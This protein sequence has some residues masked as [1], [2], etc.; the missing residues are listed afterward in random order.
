M[1][2]ES[3]TIGGDNI[4]VKE[5]KGSVDGLFARLENDI[6]RIT[7]E[8]GKPIN[9]IEPNERNRLL[10]DY[11]EKMSKIAET[12]ARLINL[13]IRGDGNTER[14]IVSSNGKGLYVQKEIIP[15]AEKPRI[16]FNFFEKNA[17]RLRLEGALNKNYPDR[18]KESKEA[19][20]NPGLSKE[21]RAE[22]NSQIEKLGI[23][24]DRCKFLLEKIFGQ[25]QG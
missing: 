15:G 8:E 3:Q 20:K 9:S 13:P 2:R 21:K 18:I 11:F 7:Q 24:E 25:R 1:I 12:E 14:M 19:L 5:I 6:K 17:T 23:D 16:E 10:R 22:K 4:E